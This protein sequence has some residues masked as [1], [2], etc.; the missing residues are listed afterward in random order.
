MK[1][2]I[3]LI[4]ISNTFKILTFYLNARIAA[5]IGSDLCSKVYQNA[6]CQPYYYHLSK[7]TN[8]IISNIIT[9][10]QIIV[11]VVNT[12]LRFVY[13]FITFIFV[14]IALFWINGKIAIF[15]LTTFG[16]MYLILPWLYFSQ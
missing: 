14:L 8:D 10:S 1:N 9:G 7:N 5:V 13:S 12:V 2:P 16:L 6:I 3:F 11:I 15:S 4:L